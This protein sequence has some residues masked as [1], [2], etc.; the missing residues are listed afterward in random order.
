MSSI[1]HDTT[2]L[3]TLLHAAIRC[4]AVVVACPLLWVG[5]KESE[6]ARVAFSVSRDTLTVGADGAIEPLSVTSSDRWYASVDDPWLNVSPAS[7][8]GSQRC[9]IQIDSTLSNGLRK[10]FVRFISTTGEQKVM[11]VLQ[12]GYGDVIHS[13]STLLHVVSSKRLREDRYFNLPVTTNVPFDI[14]IEYEGEQKGWLTAE[15]SAVVLD[16]GARPRTANLRFR[17]TN[18]A[19]PEPREARMIF[20]S[21]SSSSEKVSLTVKVVQDAAPKIEDSREGDSLAV[22]AIAEA[23]EIYTSFPTSE[24]MRNWDMVRL[25]EKTDTG[26]P[27]PEAVGR[28][29]DVLFMMA[30][31]PDGETLPVE[32]KY[33]KYLES[34]SYYSNVNSFLK[35][36]HLGTDVCSLKHLRSLQVFAMGLVDLPA[37]L[38][39]LGGTLEFLSLACNNFTAVP[40]VLTKENFPN[41]KILELHANRRWTTSDLR[42]K[43]DPY[44]DGGIGL[45]FNANTNDALRRLLLWDTLEE[46]V[47]SYNYIEGQVPDFKVGEDGV[48]AWTQA[49]VDAWG[50]DTISYLI[51]KPKI[52]P[53]AKRLTLNL[54]FFTGKAPDWL[55]YHPLLLE[56][57]PDQLIF[58]QM[59]SGLNSEGKPVRF[60]NA[61]ANYEYYF[62]AFPKYRSKY[63]IQDEQTDEQ[64]ATIARYSTDL[65][66]MKR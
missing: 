17:W 43:D 37:E 10:A 23:L 55:L 22:L 64:A 58:N 20:T 19:R 6:P 45:Y 65:L 36:V 31:V 9:D 44:Y 47:L 52:L 46:L 42:R 24:N 14:T 15:K 38:A 12:T 63:E 2:R 29:R 16:R 62:E 56:W 39:Q 35:T 25:W 51:G 61:P 66:K 11:T 50:G 60:D 13:D 21:T 8:S 59:E 40:A 32:I 53:K 28:V 18:N 54:N 33:L 41:L 48:E 57:N 30:N 3:H 49:D 5:C 34:L 1:K 27:S 7:G 26:L 4:V